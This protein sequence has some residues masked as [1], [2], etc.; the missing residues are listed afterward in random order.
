MYTFF[1]GCTKSFGQESSSTAYWVVFVAIAAAAAVAGCVVAV[2]VVGIGGVGGSGHAG[3]GS[4]SVDGA[5]VL[6]L[7]KIKI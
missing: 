3:G 5:C 1:P 6:S 2:V 7:P 4:S